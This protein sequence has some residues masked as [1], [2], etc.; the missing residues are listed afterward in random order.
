MVTKKTEKKDSIAK[1]YAAVTCPICSVTFGSVASL[2]KHNSLKPDC[3]T[4]KTVRPRCLHCPL[5]F[6]SNALKEQH[7]TLTV[8][9]QC[10]FQFGCPLALE[11]HKCENSNSPDDCSSGNLEASKR[12]S[13]VDSSVVPKTEE[14]ACSEPVETKHHVEKKRKM[15]LVELMYSQMQSEMCSNA[16]EDGSE[17]Q[18]ECASNYDEEY[19]AS[20]MLKVELHEEEGKVPLE[21]YPEIVDD[22]VHEVNMTIDELAS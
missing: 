2:E 5:V 11:L 18:D 9:E 10:K 17:E 19:C 20:D 22:V 15:T 3:L 1:S 8:C 7:T 21:E 14:E 13:S 4:V 16:D 6:F 12:P